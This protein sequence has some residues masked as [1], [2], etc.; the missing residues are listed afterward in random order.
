[1][2]EDKRRVWGQSVQGSEEAKDSCHEVVAK[3]WGQETWGT[4]GFS[5][6]RA[7]EG[8]AEEVGSLR[9]PSWSL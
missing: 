8:L 4:K 1:M 2:R 9:F 6:P 7:G 3:A 5:Q